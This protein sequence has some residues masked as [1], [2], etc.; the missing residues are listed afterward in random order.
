MQNTNETINEITYTSVAK[1]LH[2]AMALLL[3]LVMLYGMGMDDQVGSELQ[4]SLAAHA[5]GGLLLI[6]LVVLRLIWRAGH[7]PPPYPATISRAYE[8]SIRAMDY[9]MYG[10]IIF[11]LITGLITAA[12][13]AFP[14]M[15]FCKFDL[16]ETLVFLGG[17]DYDL[18]RALHANVVYLLAALII[19][20]ITAALIHQ[21]WLRDAMLMRMLPRSWRRQSQ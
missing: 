8:L 10:L 11:V 9:I 19:L 5:T 20:H 1:F 16:R 4:S 3:V 7:P 18:K 14:V 15:A 6:G 13:H 21:F 12:T 17:E 2:W